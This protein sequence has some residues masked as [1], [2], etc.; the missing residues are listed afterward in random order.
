MK[1]QE[2]KENVRMQYLAGL[3]TESQVRRINAILN[4]DENNL[5]EAKLS[6]EKQERLGDLIDQLELATD[7]DNDYYG[8]DEE[9]LDSGDIIDI[10]RQEFGDTIADQLENSNFHFPR[11]PFSPEDKLAAR[12]KWGSTSHR[13]TK[14]GK[15]HK[16]DVE[17]AKNH[18]KRG[19]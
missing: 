15:M 19:W 2:I 3:L 8:E 17:K 11:H 18:Y 6:P 7:P 13:V 12:Q 10:I 9:E 14:D 1:K 4:E 5:E 16:S